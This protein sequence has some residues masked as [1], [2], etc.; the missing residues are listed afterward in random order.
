MAIS[1]HNRIYSL[2]LYMS[3]S[4]WEGYG[5]L[6][7]M[8]NCAGERPAITILINDKVRQLFMNVSKF[9]NF[10][11]IKADAIRGEGDANYV[12]KYGL[13]KKKCKMGK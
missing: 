10:E 2:K 13:L 5:D 12:I 9:K 7:W 1:S 3:A 11:L 8:G 4:I 6:A